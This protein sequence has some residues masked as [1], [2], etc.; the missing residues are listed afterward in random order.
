[1]INYKNINLDYRKNLELM[2][3]EI[4]WSS[5]EGHILTKKSL[6]GKIKQGGFRLIQKNRA[7]FEKLIYK[8]SKESDFE[9]LFNIWCSEHSE[10]SELL[11]HYFD[12]EEYEKWAEENNIKEDEYALPDSEFAELSVHLSREHAYF[13]LCFSPIRFSE[14]QI[15]ILLNL[16]AHNK[17]DDVKNAVELEKIRSSNAELNTLKRKITKL[18]NKN[19]E[20]QK[21][22]EEKLEEIKKLKEQLKN[23]LEEVD[24]KVNKAIQE[25]REELEENKELLLKSKSQD[26]EL[27]AQLG[28]S[29][30]IIKS[31]ASQIEGLNKK[32][33]RLQEPEYFQ[34]I[35]KSVNWNEIIDYLNKP[36]EVKEL[37]LSVVKKPASDDSNDDAGNQDDLKQFWSN[38]LNKEKDTLGK[39]TKIDIMS[40]IN[41]TYF[42][43]WAEHADEFLD[44]KYSLSARL[45][46]VDML[47]E[48]L[49]EYMGVRDSE[50]AQK[51][52]KKN[53]KGRIVE[54]YKEK[55]FT[56]IHGED[57]KNYFM[58]KTA[59]VNPDHWKSLNNGKEV[60]FDLIEDQKGPSA[61][62]VR[63]L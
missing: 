38:Q 7:Y 41:K 18:S 52:I 32:I 58:H 37:L 34:K 62:N 46:L 60:S 15:D 8:E 24:L 1:M 57:G 45:V 6:S 55:S 42:R 28:K 31:Q 39:V 21:E 12:S 3:K 59:L 43:E 4:S 51:F 44:L 2:I 29:E 16:P 20:L 36:Q 54:Y 25:I 49:R 11:E 33:R 61:V 10:Y 14:K 13:F 50:I 63:I 17:K 22:N 47:Y 27:K 23:C 56:F 30:Q 35:I 9:K 53:C 19:K 48:I 40:L 26:D 5:L